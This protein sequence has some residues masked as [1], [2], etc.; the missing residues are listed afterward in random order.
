MKKLSF[1]L[2]IAIF[3]IFSCNDNEVSK[4]DLLM[5]SWMLNEITLNGEVYYQ[6][7]V[8]SKSSI[9]TFFYDETLQISVPQD[10]NI[11]HATWSL[12]NNDSEL[13]IAFSGVIN[14]YVIEKM[15][16]SNLWLVLENNEEQYMYKFIKVKLE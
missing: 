6:E 16:K 13:F 2:I 10:Q 5:N 7:A 9:Y 11:V 3:C 8:Y 15:D 12:V 1:L 4:K 14:E